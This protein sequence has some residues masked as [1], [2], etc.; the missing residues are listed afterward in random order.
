MGKCMLGRFRKLPCR[1][2]T[3]AVSKIKKSFMDMVYRQFTDVIV[4]K[5]DFLAPP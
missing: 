4:G 3:E 5:Q 2:L 1:R